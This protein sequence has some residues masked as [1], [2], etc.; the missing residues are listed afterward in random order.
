MKSEA[1]ALVA[2]CSQLESFQLDNTKKIEMDEK[3][4]AECKLLISQYE[5]KMKSLHDS[6]KDVEN[7]KRQLEEAV[8]QLNEECAKLKAADEMHKMSSKEKEMEKA[9][10]ETIKAA[11]E[12][13]IEKHREAHHKQVRRDVYCHVVNANPRSA[14]CSWRRSVMKSPKSKRRSTSCAMQIKSTRSHKID[15]Y[16]STR[17]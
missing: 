11:L 2:R 14:P 3:E 4:L 7:K 17:S 10:A 12:E 6:M 8:D 5:A 16:R 1:K 13:Q 15:S 9:S